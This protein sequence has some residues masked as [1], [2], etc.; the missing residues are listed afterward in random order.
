[1]N[2]KRLI[3]IIGF[4]LAITALHYLT[5]GTTGPLHIFYRELYF[6]PVVLAGLWGGKKGGLIASISISLLYLP[7][8]F[9]LARPH[10]TYDHHM[11]MNILIRSAESYWGNAFQILLFNLI[12]FLAGAYSDLKR[13]FIDTKEEPY[14]PTRFEK[15]FLLCVEESPASLYAAK[16]FADIFGNVPDMGVT[17]LWV[18]TEA[19]P[20]YFETPE[21]ASEYRSKRS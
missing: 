19:D 2:K 6:I 3:T 10:P 5:P 9:I 1:M 13:G 20:D 7:H 16:Y 14:Q 18:V 12:G 17:L 11:M 21:K 8:A 4:S 15:D